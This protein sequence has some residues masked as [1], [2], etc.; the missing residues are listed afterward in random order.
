MYKGF[1]CILKLHS[2]FS[3]SKNRIQIFEMLTGLTLTTQKRYELKLF[4][5]TIR[6]LT[7]LF[8]YKA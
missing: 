1:I 4:L 6:D 2:N 5:I 3:C 8:Y 7:I